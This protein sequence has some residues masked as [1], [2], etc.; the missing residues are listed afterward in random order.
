MGT[1]A[2]EQGLNPATALLLGVTR[3]LRGHGPV[4]LRAARGD[5]Y[6]SAVQPAAR[7][8]IPLFNTTGVSRRRGVLSVLLLV[9][10]LLVAAVMRAFG[11]GG[12]NLALS[13]Q[14]PVERSQTW[15]VRH[16]YTVMGQVQGFHTLNA[17]AVHRGTW[18]GGDLQT[19]TA[20]GER[21]IGYTRFRLAV[22]PDPSTGTGAAA[23]VWSAATTV[24][25]RL[26]D[27]LVQPRRV[28]E[29]LGPA[30]ELVYAGHAGDAEVYTGRNGSTLYLI[31]DRPDRVV[32]HPVRGEQTQ[33]FQFTALG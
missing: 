13:H 32:I 26:L 27:D 5:F 23:G 1:S 20:D 33:V 4:C 15:L 19:M 11:W 29:R 22:V 12:G 3:L 2:G 18:V 28:L 14:S 17:S 9:A 31:G 10:V 8:T 21:Q 7:V 24:Q 16:D 25:R 30:D 6:A